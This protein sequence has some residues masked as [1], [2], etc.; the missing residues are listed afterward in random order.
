MSRRSR[1]PFPLLLGGVGGLVLV[2][3]LPVLVRLVFGV[4]GILLS[5][6]GFAVNLAS[7][8]ALPVATFFLFRWLLTPREEA[9][10]TNRTT[11]LESRH[12]PQ[13]AVS[14]ARGYA[15][16]FDVPARE[17][18]TAQ[19][20]GSG[21]DLKVIEGI[22]PAISR[23]LAENGIRTYNDLAR[24]NQAE[25]SRILTDVGLRQ[26]SDPATWPEQARL[27]AAQDWDGLREM[28]AR[29]KAGRR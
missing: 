28:Q 27:A 15:M 25:L 18:Q 13:R 29:L 21:D 8:L 5:I 9:G 7:R 4:L 19:I 20:R 11:R 6:V 16:A 1:F 23:L 26:I 14:A 2:Q 24:T 17:F 22:G 12:S 3:L 10:E